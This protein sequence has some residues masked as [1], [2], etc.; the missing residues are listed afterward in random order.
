MKKVNKS[1]IPSSLRLYIDKNNSSDWKLLRENNREIYTEIKELIFKDQGEIC[2]YCEQDFSC[3]EEDD[4]YI[5][6][7][8]EHFHPK[9]DIASDKNW[10]LDWN[11]LLGCCTGGSEADGTEFPRP[12]NLSCDK[13]KE[14]A[15]P[16][17][18]DVEGELINPINMPA[19]PCLFNINEFT[20]E[21][22]SN[23]ENCKS[24]KFPIN[25]KKDTKELVENTINILNLN[26]DR[27]LRKRKAHIT[28]Y[29]N[30]IKSARDM[31]D[32]SIFEKLCDRFLKKSNTYHAFFTTYRILLSS[33]AETYLKN[34]N[35]SG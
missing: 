8:V 3:L 24:F 5:T 14:I 33:H 13:Y 18:N 34:N 15:L 11:N 30:L 1:I 17:I 25:N 35:F 23:E 22:F 6:R 21:L 10:A 16:N 4:D 26:C 2:A 28:N 31:R 12:N 32:D 29:Q 7:M 19:F 27:L 9:R 20:G